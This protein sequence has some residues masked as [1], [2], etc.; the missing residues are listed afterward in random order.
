MV[1]I[2]T[3]VL[4]VKIMLIVKNDENV[5]MISSVP[6]R[7]ILLHACFVSFQPKSMAVLG[8]S[9][10]TLGLYE[11]GRLEVIFLKDM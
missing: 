9:T 10:M 3:M 2:N 11:C 4:V 1:K 5:W 7:H 8:I 6:K